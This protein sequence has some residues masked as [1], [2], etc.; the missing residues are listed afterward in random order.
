MDNDTKLFEQAINDGLSNRFD[1]IAKEFDEEI[2]CSKKH[3]LRMNVILNGKIPKAPP[4]MN[5]KRLSK[6][7][8][9]ILIAIIVALTSCAI[10]YRNEIRN[11]IENSY[12]KLLILTYSGGE[13]EKDKI[14]E[15]Y[16]LTY[17]P[18]GFEFYDTF[19]F[20][21]TSK[22]IYIDSSNNTIKFEQRVLNE[23]NFYA[24][25]EKGYKKIIEITFFDVYYEKA[26]KH[27]CYFWNDGKYS[28]RITTS[29]ELSIE[30]LQK[31]IDGVKVK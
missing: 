3:E 29:L 8:I 17:L 5:Q 24:D 12:E 6:R 27:N 15:I 13:C 31:I 1:K 25:I 2:V 23:A 11:F 19:L 4:A 22:L 26:S 18:E 10:I 21:T 28:L 16:E 20:N 30:E 7:G 14:D 9:A